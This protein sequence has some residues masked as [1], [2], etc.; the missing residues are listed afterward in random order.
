MKK[1]IALVGFGTAGQ[2]FFTC[3]KKKKKHQHY[4]NNCQDQKKYF[5]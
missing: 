2:R 5:F 4:K 1:N 3:L